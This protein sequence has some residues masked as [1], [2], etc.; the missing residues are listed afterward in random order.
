[1]MM[2]ND[3]EDRINK[4]YNA[5][6]FIS[7]KI[8]SFLSDLKAAR[9]NYR[10]Y[11]DSTERM[12]LAIIDYRTFSLYIKCISVEKEIAEERKKLIHIYASG[13]L[14]ITR[15]LKDCYADDRIY[16]I[17]YQIIY[18]YIDNIHQNHRIRKYLYLLLPYLTELEIL[19][20][21]NK[22]EVFKTRVINIGIQKIK[23]RA[24]GSSFKF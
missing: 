14:I 23:Q 11:L 24:I 5:A 9:F 19:I 2:N 17:R 10:E 22:A 16:Y 15:Y 3:F 12:H 6:N 18:D 20:Q 8:D 7:D 21:E 1:M 4:N 13:L